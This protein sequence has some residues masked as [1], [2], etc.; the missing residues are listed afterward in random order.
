MCEYCF[1]LTGC[2]YCD[3]KREIEEEEKENEIP[4]FSV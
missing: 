4:E 1:D 3:E 2:I